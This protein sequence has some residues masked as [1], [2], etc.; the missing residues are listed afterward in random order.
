M[1][2]HTS[3]IHGMGQTYL[4]RR[5]RGGYW[6]LLAVQPNRH[7][8]VRILET[9]PHPIC[10]E[11]QKQTKKNHQ[12]TP[13]HDKWNNLH[14]WC[15]CPTFT[16]GPELDH[17]QTQQQGPQLWKTHG[18]K[19]WIQGPKR[20]SKKKTRAVSLSK[21]INV[22]IVVYVFQSD[23]I[24]CLSKQWTCNFSR[25]TNHITVSMM[26]LSRHTILT[27]NCYKLKIWMG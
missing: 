5:T 4:P 19:R 15:K 13:K 16:V 26:L 2:K 20:Q 14:Q 10:I 12:F 21:H 22:A 27:V 1:G 3:P 8:G 11:S 17:N 23:D 7:L 18:F 25:S 24:F 9:T 6:N